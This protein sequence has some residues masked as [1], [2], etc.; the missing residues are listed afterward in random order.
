LEEK[1]NTLKKV[2]ERVMTGDDILRRLGM[3]NVR[4]TYAKESRKRPTVRRE[5]IPA[6]IN[7]VGEKG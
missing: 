2:H 6:K 1:L 4:R 3:L 7:F 5:L